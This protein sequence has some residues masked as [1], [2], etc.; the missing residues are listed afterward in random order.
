MKGE[1]NTSGGTLWPVE[2]SAQTTL[3]RASGNTVPTMLRGRD[4]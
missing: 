3:Q 1:W 2:G 4:G